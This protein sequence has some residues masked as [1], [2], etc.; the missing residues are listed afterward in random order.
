MPGIRR[1]RRSS[2]GWRALLTRF[3]S[4]GLTVTAFC[5]REVVSPASFYRWRSL[6]GVARRPSLRERSMP[7]FAICAT[8]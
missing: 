2:E 4:S 7:D 5:Q 8:R 3:A 1:Q 6:L